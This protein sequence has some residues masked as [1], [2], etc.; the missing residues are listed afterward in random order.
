M[1]SRIAIKKFFIGFHAVPL[2]WIWS[3]N[4]ESVVK[5]A[6]QRDKSGN[7]I[8]SFYY[9]RRSVVPLVEV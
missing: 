7:G 1:L 3:S 2:N 8:S 9:S 5:L 6:I 4:K